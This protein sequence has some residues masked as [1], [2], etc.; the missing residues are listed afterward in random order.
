MVA[1]ATTDILLDAVTLAIVEE[2]CLTRRASL[3]VLPRGEPSLGVVGQQRASETI[4]GCLVSGY[5]VSN[6]IGECGSVLRT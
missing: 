5:S 4:V 6:F 2:P 1:A 3:G